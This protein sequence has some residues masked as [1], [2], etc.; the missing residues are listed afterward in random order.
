MI[1]QASEFI[2]TITEPI[3]LLALTILIAIFLYTKN[4][5][6]QAILLTSTSIFTALA[7]KTIKAIVQAPRPLTSLIQETGYSFPSGHTTF[8]VVFFGL[9]TY[10]FTKPKHRTPA[11]ITSAL[12][13]AIIIFSRLQLQVH[14][15]IDIIGG[16]IIGIVILITSII[17]HKKFIP[18]NF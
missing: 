5:K 13:I 12:L 3:L 9:M 17:A 1:T 11:I 16:I 10:I 4:K 7:I 8:A 14:H 2:A 18:S 6:S 15:P